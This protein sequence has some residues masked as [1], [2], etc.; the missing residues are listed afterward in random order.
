MNINT[1]DILSLIKVCQD[2]DSGYSDNDTVGL[3]ARELGISKVSY[4]VFFN[5]VS[6]ESSVI[7]H[8]ENAS[9]GENFDFQRV[10]SNDRLIV[11]KIYRYVDAPDLDSEGKHMLSVFGESTISG[12]CVK[13][14]VKAYENARYYDSLTKLTNLNYFYDH[15]DRL[16][17]SDK[18]D[19]YS[20]AITNIKNCGAINRIFGSKIADSIIRD[21]AQDSLYLFDADNYEVISRLAGD[22]FIMTLKTEHLDKVLNAMNNSIVSVDING[23]IVDYNIEIRAGIVDLHSNI[24]NT[25]DIIH[26]AEYSL[27]N[28]RLDDYPDFYTINSDSTS[29][30]R[31]S[32][33]TAALI[34][35]E[36]R[37]NRLQVYF[38]PIIKPDG[39]NGDYKLCAAQAVLRIRIDGSLKDP[40]DLIV[41][42]GNADLLKSVNSYLLTKTCEIMNEWKTQG[43]D[44][45]PIAISLSFYD[46][47][48]TAFADNVI[49]YIDRY[50]IDR[51]KI[52]LDFSA[53]SIMNRCG[54]IK[55]AINKFNNAH[56]QTAI[57]DYGAT[58]S[59]LRSLSEMSFDYLKISPEIVNSDSKS[60]EIILKHTIALAHELGY[61]SVC[62]DPKSREKGKAAFDFGCKY[63]IGDI[64][65]KALSKRFFERKLKKPEYTVVNE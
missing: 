22:S 29:S 31:T 44:T 51:S 34:A 17:S 30:N 48:N 19:L 15:L 25:G 53:P 16:L 27:I 23:D 21:F 59:S 49:H 14:I 13:N 4:R 6:T 37:E 52:I 61:I 64:Y 55:V 36:L 57:S 3:F 58:A 35:E 45:V 39:D 60:D 5:D 38:K 12:I 62:V 47:F 43:I 50:Q 65:D 33:E 28:S 40:Y 56:I 32:S 1:D 26:L 42:E 2:F 46:Y 9:L 24:R 8:A 54:E 20:V 11:V 63:F 41:T 10:S 7:Y 18:S